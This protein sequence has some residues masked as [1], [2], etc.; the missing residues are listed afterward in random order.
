MPRRCELTGKGTASGNNVSHAHNRTRRKFY[1]NLT[2]VSLISDALGETISLRVSTQALR[3]V[4]FKGGLDKFLVKA[5]DENLSL[6]ARRLKRRIKKKV[7]EASAA[8]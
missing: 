6:K 1:P 8:A 4:E 7:A 5:R 3:T 2:K